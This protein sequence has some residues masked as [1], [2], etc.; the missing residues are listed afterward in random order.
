MKKDLGVKPYIM[1]MPVLIIG[2]YS[3]DGTPDAMNA[4]WGTL[5]EMNAVAL[6]LAG[7]HK[8]AENIRA[9][10]AFTVALAD[11]ANLVAADYV[12]IVSAHKEK[13]KVAKAGWTVTRSSRVDA[14]VINELPLT[15]ECT[16]DYIDENTGCV[17]GEI[18]NVVADEKVLDET[19]NVDL[20]KLNPLSYDH[21]SLCYFTVGKKVGK[22]FSVGK[23]LK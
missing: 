2:T 15:L 1:P 16:L 22:A 19:G 7:S 14:P 6:Y 18:V 11:E 23:E 9:K 21:A 13:N 12:G 8:T 4:A 20:N 3:E 17:Y 10:K 5:S